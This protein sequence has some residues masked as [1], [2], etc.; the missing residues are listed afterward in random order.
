MA[1]RPL[2]SVFIERLRAAYRRLSRARD[3]V[4][5][6]RYNHY[7]F[8]AEEVED[9]LRLLHILI[10]PE[11]S[12]PITVAF[13]NLQARLRSFDQERDPSE[14]TEHLF[15]AMRAVAEVVQQ[16]WTVVDPTQLPRQKKRQRGPR[17]PEL[18]LSRRPLTRSWVA[19]P[20]QELLAFTEKWAEDE[21]HSSS[22]VGHRRR[23]TDG[24]EP[25][26][27]DFPSSLSRQVESICRI[28]Q[29]QVGHG[30]YLDADVVCLAVGML[31]AFLETTP[32]DCLDLF[33]RVV[34]AGATVPV[35]HLSARKTDPES[36]EQVRA[37]AADLIDA[38]AYR[39]VPA[40]QSPR[41]LL[42]S[43]IATAG[44]ITGASGCD[45][46]SAFNSVQEGHAL[47]GKMGLESMRPIDPDRRGLLR[48]MSAA[49]PLAE[50]GGR[51]A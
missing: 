6:L 34:K 44:L 8:A 24:D 50:T 14:R 42:R 27:P 15:S 23:R 33:E 38:A 13:D 49:L 43:L 45:S 12:S 10:E 35:Q 4:G 3:S 48:L 22:A 9:A 2:E 32:A 28:W 31:A 21:K 16:F 40:E 26:P 7:R 29:M 47:F 51:H 19:A 25:P 20:P 36:F 18:D 30:R 11:R 17:I 46:K 1:S 41:T 5:T 37:W 39:L